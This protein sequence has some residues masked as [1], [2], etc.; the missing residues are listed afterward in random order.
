MQ[1]VVPDPT[2]ELP[3]VSWEALAT[4]G[5]HEIWNGGLGGEAGRVSGRFLG[6]TEG[7]GWVGPWVSL[8]RKRGGRQDSLHYHED[9]LPA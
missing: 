7:R 6:A 5:Q 1:A 4:I 3:W 9:V 8:S 2:P